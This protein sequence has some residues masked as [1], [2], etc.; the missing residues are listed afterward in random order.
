MDYRSLLPGL[1]DA[2]VTDGGRAAAPDR[3]DGAVYVLTEDLVI[4]VDVALA[5]GRPLLLRGAP[6]SGKSS[7]AAFLA[8]NLGW[9]YYEHV[10]TSRTR[11][12][13]LLYDYDTVRRLAD[14]SAAKSAI[15]DDDYVE[16]AVLWWAFARDSAVR[17]GA[18]DGRPAGRPAREPLADINEHRSGAGAVVLIDEIDKADPDVPNGLLVPLG[19]TEFEVA[20]TATTVRLVSPGTGRVP[21]LIIVTTNEER[22]L[23]PAFVRRCIVHELPPPDRATLIEIGRRHLAQRA[24]GVSDADERLLAMVADRFAELHQQATAAGRRAPSTAEY[25]DAVLTCRAFGVDASSELWRRMER[26]VLSKDDAGPSRT[27]R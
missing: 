20:E 13:D 12:R 6:G 23:P 8:R 18:P 19:S 15:V 3:R 16:P 17:R 24:G 7:L 26:L 10:V 22:E 9:R 21:Y 4:A 14:A 1:R 11:A 25:L 27:T 5:T 2:P